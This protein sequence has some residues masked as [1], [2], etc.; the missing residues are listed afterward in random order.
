MKTLFENLKEEHKLQ[1][2]VMKEIYPNSHARLVKTLEDN[3]RKIE[4]IIKDIPR[5]VKNQIGICILDK[6]GVISLEVFDSQISS[7]IF[8]DSPWNPGDSFSL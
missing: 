2:E 5:I 8:P 4:D 1:L 6:E 3:Q 7:G